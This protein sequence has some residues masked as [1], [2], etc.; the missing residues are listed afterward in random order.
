MNDV[1]KTDI[2]QIITQKLLQGEKPEDICRGLECDVNA[3]YA[4]Q[5]SDNFA[6][7]AIEHLE[8]NVK[9]ASVKALQNIIKVAEDEK[10]S[11]ATRLKANQY[12]VDKALE[13]NELGGGEV[14]PATMS[15]QQLATR[16]AQ[17]QKEAKKRIKEDTPQ[18]LNDLL[19]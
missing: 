14:S 16:L 5:S 1:V 17:L 7:A 8:K 3:V 11:Q 12:I 19:A 2:K 9:A 6:Q 13:F 18:N 15:Q 10:A 4:V